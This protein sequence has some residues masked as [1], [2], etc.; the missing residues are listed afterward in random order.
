MLLWEKFKNSCTSI[1]LA[2]AASELARQ[3]LYDEAKNLMI[4]GNKEVAKQREAIKR[5]E[6][7]KKA[8]ADYEPGDHYMRGHKV[9]FWKGH[10]D[11]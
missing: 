4:Y 9:A 11:A 8:K 7:V 3:G 1:G 6:R 2:R 5:L 10:A